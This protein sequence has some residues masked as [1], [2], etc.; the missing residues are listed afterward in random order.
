MAE[1]MYRVNSRITVALV[2]L[3][4]LSAG[5]IA[6]T[7]IRSAR[8]VGAVLGVELVLSNL[9]L[10]DGDNP[11]VVVTFRLKNGSPVRIE[12]EAFDVYLY[13]DS[14]YIGTS[15]HPFTTRSISGREETTMDFVIP[16]L[17]P[18]VQFTEQARREE[19]FSW[20]VRGKAKVLF[21]SFKGQ[22]VW[23]HVREY[24]TSE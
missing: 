20:F 17:S 16:I 3:A 12:L 24:W 15:Y 2:F 14:H 13:L 5:S 8:G 7:A 23:L 10:R 4:V 1:R 21:P 19:G 6:S 11:E 22:E 9:E 18:H